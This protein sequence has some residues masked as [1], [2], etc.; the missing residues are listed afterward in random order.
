[1]TVFGVRSRQCRRRHVFRSG[2]GLHKFTVLCDRLTRPSQPHEI[3]FLIMASAI[4]VVTF[5]F[6]QS[7]AWT[8][9]N[10]VKIKKK[11]FSSEYEIIIIKTNNNNNNNNKT[12]M[13]RR[14]HIII[15]NVFTT[16]RVSKLVG[17]DCIVFNYILSN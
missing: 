9:M 14:E 3:I 4:Y 7:T 16:L 13:K 8:Q 17:F 6:Y 15:T 2:G 5:F 1:M 10:T 12:N 11:G